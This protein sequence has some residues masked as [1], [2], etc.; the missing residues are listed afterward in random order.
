MRFPSRNLLPVLALAAL[1]PSCQGPWNLQ[2]QEPDPPTLRISALPVAGRTWDTVWVERIQ[3][4]ALESRGLA[5]VGPGSWLRI[6]VKK[7]LGEDTIRFEPSVE[8][9]RA[10]IARDRSA[11]VPWGA[12]LHLEAHLVWNSS[13]AFPGSTEWTESDVSGDATTPVRY[14]LKPTMGAPLDVFFRALAGGD[15]G[16]DPAG[17]LEVLRSEDDAKVRGLGVTEA[18]CDSFL[19]GRW[20]QR[21]FRSGDTAWAIADDRLVDDRFGRPIKRSLRPFLVEQEVDLQGW[22]GLVSAIEFDPTRARI[23]GPIQR[24]GFEI[25]G[26]STLERE[27]SLGLYQPGSSRML[28]VDGPDQAG[29]MGYP[30]VMALPSMLLSVTGRNVVRTLAVDRAYVAYHQA[31]MENESGQWAYSSLH[32]ATGFFSGGAADSLV[33]QVRAVRDTFALPVLREMW[34][35]DQAGRPARERPV[36]HDQAC[37]S[38]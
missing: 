31:M 26:N 4:L 32:G 3:P 18:T 38:R 28:S 13:A 11:L 12:S 27:D 22:G 30:Q 34:C 23:L 9:P 35:A 16:A 1:L 17:L 25:R 19:R 20:V 6:L 2:P 7:P 8:N 15:G 14:G 10:W 24:V 33:F 21:T 37:G 36:W 29:M 5:F